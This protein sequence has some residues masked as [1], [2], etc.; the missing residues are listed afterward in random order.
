MYHTVYDPVQEMYQNAPEMIQY[1]L[2]QHSEWNSLIVL[3]CDVFCI[4]SLSD[5]FTG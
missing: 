1:T 2:S 4:L 5:G 3:S